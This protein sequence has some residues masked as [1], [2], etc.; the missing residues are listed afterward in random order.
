MAG[1]SPAIVITTHGQNNSRASFAVLG[2]IFGRPDF[3]QRNFEFNEHR[4]ISWLLL[5]AHKAF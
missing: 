5:L 4:S 2:F 1:N 3:N